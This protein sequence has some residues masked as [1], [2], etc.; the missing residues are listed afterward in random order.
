ML[1]LKHVAEAL[2][3]RKAV[4]ILFMLP[5]ST[6]EAFHFVQKEHDACLSGRLEE[7]ATLDFAQLLL[8]CVYFSC[9]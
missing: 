6:E 4:N 5:C 3:S 9:V 1:S 2:G 7:Y 8:E